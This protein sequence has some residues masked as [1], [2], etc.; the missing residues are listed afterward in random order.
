MRIGHKVLP[1]DETEN[2]TKFVVARHMVFK[3]VMWRANDRFGSF[4][5]EM[6]K[7]QTRPCPLQLR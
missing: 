1:L 4:S 2:A 6:V 5:T 3:G 7:A